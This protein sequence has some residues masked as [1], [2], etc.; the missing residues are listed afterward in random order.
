MGNNNFLLSDIQNKYD[1]QL[2]ELVHFDCY[3]DTNELVEKIKYYLE[4]ELERNKIA[5]SGGCII[6]E[7]Y[8]LTNALKLIFS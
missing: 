5:Y 7:K 2:E 3:S 8:N 4:H 6:R 1:L